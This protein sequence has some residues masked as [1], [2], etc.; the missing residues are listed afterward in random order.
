MLLG[1]LSGWAGKQR[2][3]LNGL[4]SLG[5]LLGMAIIGVGVISAALG[6]WLGDKID[7]RFDLHMQKRAKADSTLL[8]SVHSVEMALTNYTQQK[9]IQD[10]KDSLH[11]ERN[12][13]HIEDNR[14]KLNTHEAKIGDHDARIRRIEIGEA[15]IIRSL[16]GEIAKKQDKR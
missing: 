10:L 6:N 13:D 11:I 2:D 7:G 8:F 14:K 3:K 15:S 9:I 5:K 12:E 16:R 4:V 1:R